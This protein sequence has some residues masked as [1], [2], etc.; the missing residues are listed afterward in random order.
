[1][2]LIFKALDGSTRDLKLLFS[3][4]YL[5]GYFCFAIANIGAEA[6]GPIVFLAPLLSWP[7]LFVAVAILGKADTQRKLFFVGLMLVHYGI[8]FLVFYLF[9]DR[10]NFFSPRILE[11]WNREPVLQIL[12]VTWYFLGQFLIWLAFLLERNGRSSTRSD[13]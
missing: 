2:G 5:I 11:A 7:V 6:K 10:F 13:D 12:T 4:T 3:A 1:M 8:T 9:T